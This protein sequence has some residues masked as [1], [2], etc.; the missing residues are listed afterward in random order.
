MSF[1]APIRH[2]IAGSVLQLQS[3]PQVQSIW[4]LDKER[5]RRL[6]YESWKYL[7]W[8]EKFQLTIGIG[9]QEEVRKLVRNVSIYSQPFWQSLP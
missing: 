9:E 2:S 8:D 5:K 1:D 7:P 3:T 4:N 6:D